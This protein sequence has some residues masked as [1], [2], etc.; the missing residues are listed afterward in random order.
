ML[1]YR[2]HSAQAQ[3]SREATFSRSRWTAFCVIG[4]LLGLCFTSILLLTGYLFEADDVPYNWSSVVTW[5]WIRMEIIALLSSVSVGAGIAL[6]LKRGAQRSDMISVLVGALGG[7]ILAVLIMLTAIQ[8]IP[9][10]R[11]DIWYAESPGF[12][13]TILI[14][15]Y[16]LSYG[17]L[18]LLIPVVLLTTAQ[19]FTLP[20]LRI[21]SLWVLLSLLGAIAGLVISIG[22]SD[23]FGDTTAR[24]ATA[25]S[26]GIP[27]ST[28]VGMTLGQ[29]VY[30]GWGS[31]TAWRWLWIGGLSNGLL[32]SC[33]ALLIISS[34]YIP[35]INFILGIAILI[36][37]GRVTSSVL[38]AVR[39]A[40]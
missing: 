34:I 7:L 37:Y 25:F 32:F 8:S 19:E 29:V 22:L 28:A 31:P 16:A 17:L 26:I 20:R 4:G 21:K 5:Q 2:E 38:S 27:L 13:A 23:T 10:T 33:G 12:E 39:P 6:L 18:S 24:T 35:G 15:A 40:A 11:T 3:V 36:V 14:P 9:A 30:L 1:R